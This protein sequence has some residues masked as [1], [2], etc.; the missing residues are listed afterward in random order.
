MHILVIDDDD[1]LRLLLKQYL[2]KNKFKVSTCPNIEKANILLQEFSFDII[3]LD[4]M[5]PGKTGIEF[6]LEKDNN[7]KTPVLL[8]TALDQI[9]DKIKGLK[10]GADDYLTKPFEP[11][12]LL[13]RIN[14]I[15]KRTTI[16]KKQNIKFLEFGDYKWDNL[17][18]RLTKKGK[19]I[20]TTTLENE[21]L[22]IFSNNLGSYLNRSELSKSLKINSSSRNIDVGITRLRKKIE[23]NPKNPQY[24]LNARGKGWQ[25]RGR[26]LNN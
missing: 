4:V 20:H 5:M 16:S 19:Y 13:L 22:S 17:L 23:D 10:S 21:L 9:T 3:I 8:L 11:E 26:A 15:L 25:I 1:R 2:S 12:E 24:I 14:N 6:L 7:I 18:K